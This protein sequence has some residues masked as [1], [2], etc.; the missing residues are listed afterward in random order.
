MIVFLIVLYIKIQRVTRESNLEDR[1]RK[2]ELERDT[3][4]L[5]IEDTRIN[6]YTTTHSR[7]K[8]LYN[9]RITMLKKYG[10]EY[11][12]QSKEVREKIKETCLNKYGANSILGNEE[13][14][15][16][17]E[18]NTNF[19]KLDVK[20]KMVRTSIEKYR[21]CHPQQNPFIKMKIKKT[22]MEKYGTLNGR[23]KKDYFSMLSG[24]VDIN[25]FLQDNIS[26]EILL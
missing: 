18:I 16:K 23:G 14:R 3:L 7:I 26:G 24:F 9:R 12:L 6:K 25:L 19:K 22:K 20:R 17:Y 11:P 15:K 10:V 1:I 21:V 13:F 5:S 4:L 8:G 2:L